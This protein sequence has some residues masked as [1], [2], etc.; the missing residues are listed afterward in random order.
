MDHSRAEKH[1]PDLAAD[2][3]DGRCRDDVMSHVVGCAECREWLGTYDM[4]ASALE[5]TAGDEHPDAELL[6]LCAVRPDEL[7][8]SDRAELR[9][10][11]ETCAQCRREVDAAGAAVRDARPSPAAPVPMPTS[12][13]RRAAPW[14]LAVAATL[15]ACAIGALVV[16]GVHGWSA[17]SALSGDE[18]GVRVVDGSASQPVAPATRLSD[19]QIHGDRVIEA[20]GDLMISRTTIEDGSQVTIRA[21]STVVIG[22]GFQVGNQARITVGGGHTADSVEVRGK[23]G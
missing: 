9:R 16:F 10:H 3:L 13:P 22:N 1:L 12:S 18:A 7:Y 23:R 19:T 4:L 15:A 8:E 2:G 11:L 20:P 5:E 17:R 14:R 21:G 6:A